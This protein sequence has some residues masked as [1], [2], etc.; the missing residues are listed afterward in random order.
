[1]GPTVFYVPRTQLFGS[2]VSP[3]NFS[4]LPIWTYKLMANLFAVAMVLCVDDVICTE[5]SLTIISACSCWKKSFAV[6]L[7]GTFL[8]RR[9]HLRHG[10]YVSLG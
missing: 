7:G 2:R 4:R 8:T 3:V 6:F 9:A 1:M 10:V 5:R